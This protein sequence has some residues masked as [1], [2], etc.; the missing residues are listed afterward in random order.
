MMAVI[1]CG[2]MLKYT[3]EHMHCL[4]NIYGALAPANTGVLAVQSTAPN[5][6]VRCHSSRKTAEDSGRTGIAARP[7]GETS[8]S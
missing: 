4:A 7:A 6:R 3:P 2:R 8:R 5:Q 1:D